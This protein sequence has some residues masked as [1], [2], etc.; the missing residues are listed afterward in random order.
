MSELHISILDVVLRLLA[1]VV[2]SG[3][4]G[5]N[6]EM[7]RKPAGVRT[8]M[9]VSL[10]SAAFVIVALELAHG[11]IAEILGGDAKPDPTRVLEGIVHAIGFLGAGAIIQARGSVVGLTT[12]VSVWIAGG[13]GVACGGGFYALAAL[14]AAMAFVILAA[15]GALEA[16]FGSDSVDG[17]KPSKGSRR[18]S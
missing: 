16:C 11:P 6:R 1:A 9:L 10:G 7:H 14:L 18:N 8:H 4:I 13:I 3:I 17:G 12:G 2:L 15:I 5:F